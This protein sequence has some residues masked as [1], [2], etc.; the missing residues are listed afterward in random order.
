M[1]RRPHTAENQNENENEKENGGERRNASI[2]GR[3]ANKKDVYDFASVSLEL[4]FRRNFRASVLPFPRLADSIVYRA[5][6]GRLMN[7]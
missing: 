5:R 1:Q 6:V 3:T 2:F 7:G 4:V